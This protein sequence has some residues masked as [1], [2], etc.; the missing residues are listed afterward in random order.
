MTEPERYVATRSE[1]GLL[2][3]VP[4]EDEPTRR[5]SSRRPSQPPTDDPPALVTKDRDHMAAAKKKPKRYSP[6]EKAAVMAKVAESSAAQVSRETGI[7]AELAPVRKQLQ[8][9]VDAMGKA[10]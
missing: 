9:L 8:N 6:E 4:N 2:Q 1:P 3:L 7:R 10:P 5:L